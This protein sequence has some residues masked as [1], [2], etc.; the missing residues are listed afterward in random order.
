MFVEKFA[1][2][3]ADRL[4]RGAVASFSLAAIASMGIA[5]PAAAQVSEE[6]EDFWNGVQENANVTGPRADIGQEGGY[7]T[8]GS[9]VYRAPQDTLQVMSMTAPSIRAGCG[10]IDI[11]TGGFSFINADQFVAHLRALAANAQ[12]YA[13]SLALKTLCPM[14]ES[15]VSNAQALAQEV[16][17]MNMNSC[18][19]ARNLVDAVWPRS[20]AASEYICQSA[21]SRSGMFSD[22]VEARHQCGSGGSSGPSDSTTRAQRPVNVNIAWRALTENGLFASSPEVAEFMMSLTGTV[23]VTEGS[24]ANEGPTYQWLPPLATSLE[25]QDALFAGGQMPVYEC[26]DHDG[27]LE[28]YSGDTLIAPEDAL[29]ARVAGLI[30][31]ILNAIATEQP[32]SDEQRAFLNST[33]LPVYRIMSVNYA[34]K[35]AMAEADTPQLAQYIAIELMTEFLRNAMEEAIQ[36]RTVVEQA[37]M[38]AEFEEWREGVADVIQALEQRQRRVGENHSYTFEVVQNY[39]LIERHLAARLE[40]RMHDALSGMRGR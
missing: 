32:L 8:G 13:F 24:N 7:F 10:G 36:S 6:L 11:F 20:N 37:S 14:C 31:G 34:Y 28:P 21:G 35:G 39:Q 3:A 27:C 38:S 5:S 23:V 17:A 40:R 25:L 29:F 15:A 18:E 33:S 4:L 9:L 22:W 16:N 26:N 30:N 12:G 19:S 1:R 2:T